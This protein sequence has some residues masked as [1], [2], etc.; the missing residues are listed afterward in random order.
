[1]DAEALLKPRR[2]LSENSGFTV[3]SDADDD[4]VTGITVGV[5]ILLEMVIPEGVVVESEVGRGASGLEGSA[6]GEVESDREA[7]EST[8]C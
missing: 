7:K 1:M 2:S 8:E 3:V 4:K 5:V 6:P